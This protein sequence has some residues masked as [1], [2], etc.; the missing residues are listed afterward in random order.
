MALGTLERD[1]HIPHIPSTEGRLPTSLK[2][3]LELGNPHYPLSG[4]LIIVRTSYNHAEGPPSRSWGFM[5]LSLGLGWYGRRLLQSKKD[6]GLSGLGF[7]AVKGFL[8]KWPSVTHGSPQSL[9][10]A[11]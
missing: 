8:F 5:E 9:T 1:P 7:R 3:V 2:V 10:K 6:C 11:T 4:V